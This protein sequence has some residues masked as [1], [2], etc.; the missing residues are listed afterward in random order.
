[1]SEVARQAADRADRAADWLGEREPGDV[2]DEIRSFA[3]RRPGAF[4]IGA[5]LAGVVVGRLTRGAVDAA[6]SDSGQH[7]V[8][9][10]VRTPLPP[11]PAYGRP[12]GTGLPVPTDTPTPPQG[13]VAPR[14]YTSEP[15]GYPAGAPASPLPPAAAAPAYDSDPLATSAAQAYDSDPLAAPAAPGGGHAPGTVGEYV[16]DLEQAAEDRR[17]AAPDERLDD[18]YRPGGDYR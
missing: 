15:T 8:G 13:Y 14:P 6:R 5:A 1:V 11:S 9:P 12:T 10:R 18:P 7:A 2:V 16:D 17:S 4:L 3:R